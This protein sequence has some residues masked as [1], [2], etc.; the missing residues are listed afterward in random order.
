MAY[1]KAPYRYFF[2]I[3]I[4]LN[5]IIAFQPIKVAGQPVAYIERTSGVGTDVVTYF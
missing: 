1:C 4:Y 3:N 2:G 5:F